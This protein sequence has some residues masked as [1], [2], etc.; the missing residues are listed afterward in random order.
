MWARRALYLTYTGVIIIVYI[1]GHE[2][3]CS[4]PIARSVAGLASGRRRDHD[5]R[6]GHDSGALL[7]PAGPVKNPGDDVALRRVSHVSQAVLCIVLSVSYD[8]LGSVTVKYGRL[9]VLEFFVWIV[10]CRSER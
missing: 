9:P 3:R 5:A 10:R 6:T 7:V 4:S 2:K 8:R 1:H